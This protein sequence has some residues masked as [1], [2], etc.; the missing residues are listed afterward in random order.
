MNCFGGTVNLHKNTIASTETYKPAIA[1][2]KQHFNKP[3]ATVESV[4]S[5]S[6]VAQKASKE[7]KALLP[8]WGYCHLLESA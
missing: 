2:G 3:K 6:L 8:L 1:A 7:R 5:D 4:L